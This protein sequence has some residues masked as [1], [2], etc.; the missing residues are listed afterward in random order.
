MTEH[1]DGPSLVQAR[2]SNEVDDGDYFPLQHRHMPRQHQHHARFAKPNYLKHRSLHQARQEPASDLETDAAVVT[3]VVQTISVVQVLDPDGQTL[4]LTT[5]VPELPSIAD[6]EILPDPPELPAPDGEPAPDPFVDVFADPDPTAVSLG[7]DIAPPSPTLPLTP[8]D[9]D[10]SDSFVDVTSL[11]LSTSSAPFPTPSGLVNSSSIPRMCFGSSLFTSIKSNRHAIALSTSSSLFVNAS[12]PF[13][14]ANSTTRSLAPFANSTFTTSS[15]TVT[16]SELPV[17]FIGGAD[18]GSVGGGDAGEPTPTD[19]AVTPG[20]G[21][22]P[23]PPPVPVSTVAGGVVGGIAGV[24]LLVIMALFILR[25]RKRQQGLVDR[26][27][28]SG[29]TGLLT[30]SRG[31]S[32]TLDGK[33]GA[34]MTEVTPQ[35]TMPGGTASMI[36]FAIPAALAALTGKPQPASSR[37][38]A[39]TGERG[40]YRVSG[41]KLPPALFTG[42][43]GYTEPAARDSTYSDS[44]S[45]T[46]RDSHAFFVGEGGV[47]GAKGGPRLALGSPMRP[48]SGVPIIR[49]SPARTPV[50]ER[51][52]I[53]D[54]HTSLASPLDGPLPPP[55]GVGRSLV[56]LDGSRTTRGSGSKFTEEM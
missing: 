49:D 5:L 34:A 24:A 48:E 37:G 13:F 51:G 50:T 4:H 21:D 7:L 56:S 8:P 20:S 1:E 22:A 32:S 33:S 11:T 25:W 23:K 54:R 47:P 35:G 6:P 16:A 27:R 39:A 53:L 15:A 28:S 29:L 30:G 55:D 12:L 10:F 9:P 14:H 46:F 36:P 31:R 18:P 45:I 42:G 17:G 52:P 41:R 38:G 43:D 3:E 2:H 19:A 40:F 26:D 44:A